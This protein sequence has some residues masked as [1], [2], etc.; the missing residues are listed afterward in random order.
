MDDDGEPPPRRLPAWTVVH[1]PRVAVRRSA[2][3]TA[4]MAGSKLHGEVVAASR[5]AGGWIELSDGGWMLVDGSCVG[6]GVL[7]ERVPPP[8]EA[9]TLRFSHPD[10]GRPLHE[11]ATTMVATVGQTKSAV[12]AAT[13]LRAGAMVLARGKQGQRISDS[14]E[15]LF[16]DHETLW[17][18]GYV[19][20]QEVGYMYMG[21]AASDL[22]RGRAQ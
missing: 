4:P 12:A 17:A 16:R 21:E 1:R 5:E 9:L 15:N 13:G 6:L 10:T 14:A 20:G 19:D 8:N 7:L 11:L 2:D 3:V 22:A 18:C